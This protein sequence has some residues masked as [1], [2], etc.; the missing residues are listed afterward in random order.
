VSDV[1]DPEARL[2]FDGFQKRSRL[3]KL[4]LDSLRSDSLGGV[5]GLAG[6]FMVESGSESTMA[7]REVRRSCTLHGDSFALIIN[8]S[9]SLSRYSNGLAS[10]WARGVLGL[11]VWR[12]VGSQ[13]ACKAAENAVATRLGFASTFQ[14]NY[15]K[16][17]VIST[18]Q[19][20]A[21]LNEFLLS[22]MLQIRI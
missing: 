15:A 16:T 13:F 2:E 5:G 14:F 10:R 7:A 1:W 21:Q 19:A 8:P 3:N 6:R 18:L 22:S 9:P 12:A 4:N 20:P 11:I 17:H